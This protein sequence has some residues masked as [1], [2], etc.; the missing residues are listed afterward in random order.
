MSLLNFL[1][2]P[3]LVT[4]A[5]TA[6]NND[7]KETGGGREKGFSNMSSPEKT[8]GIL[9]LLDCAVLYRRERESDKIQFFIYESTR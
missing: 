9:L 2:T 6:T 3:L 7:I 4:A 1:L 8:G 5:T